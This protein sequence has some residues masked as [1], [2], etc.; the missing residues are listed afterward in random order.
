M[1]LL[2]S[3]L[4]DYLAPTAA[5]IAVILSQL[6][7]V[8]TWLKKKKPLVTVGRFL[9]VTHF[10]GQP[11][12]QLYVSIL[13]DSHSSIRIH[14]IEVVLTKFGKDKISLP[15]FSIFERTEN[16]LQKA[17]SPFTLKSDSEWSHTLRF[18]APFDGSEEQ[19]FKKLFY[20]LKNN[21]SELIIE[22]NKKVDSER[23]DLVEADNDIV[24]KLKEI[25]HLKRFWENAEYKLQLNVTTDSLSTSFQAEYDFFLSMPDVE[26]L[27]SV[28]ERYKYGSSILITDTNVFATV[29]V[30][31]KNSALIS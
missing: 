1:P 10:I 31:N 2:S 15:V 9:S 4:K 17:F 19:N 28:I 21:I 20:S 5:V 13:N 25:Y 6:P 12:L 7:P 16:N 30:R 23:L 22:N 8:K 27:E 14:N 18:Y 24:E 11:E 26:F 29:I 3:I